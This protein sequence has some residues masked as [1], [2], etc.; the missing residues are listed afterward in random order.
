MKKFI[1]LLALGIVSVATAQ[2]PAFEDVDTNSDGEISRE[3][4]AVVEGLDL[5]RCDKDGDEYLS[6]EEYTVCGRPQRE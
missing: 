5:V 4:A 1:P 3:E 6:R 2:F